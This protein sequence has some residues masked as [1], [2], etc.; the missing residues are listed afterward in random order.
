MRSS[1]KTTLCLFIIAGVIVR[2]EAVRQVSLNVG[3]N[4]ETS[5]FTASDNVEGCY[6][7]TP[8]GETIEFK[9]VDNSNDKYKLEEDT[10]FVKCKV[11]VKSINSNDAGIWTLRSAS[12]NGNNR[13][14]TYEVTVTTED[15]AETT[16]LPQ[17]TT[18]NTIETST[19]QI[20]EIINID[21]EHFVTKI[22][23]SHE[24]K[25]PEYDFLNSEK[26]YIV[27]PDGN[28]YDVEMTQINGI[29][30]IKDDNVACGVKVHIV[31]EQM[32]GDWMLIS[33]GTRYST[34]V[35]ERRLP[36][37]IILEEIVNALPSEITV[38]QG[39]DIYIRLEDSTPFYDTCK[40]IDP[41][42]TFRT[43]IEKDSRYVDT[44]GFIVKNASE[45]DSGFWQI[46]YGESTIY[47]AF[48]R[49]TVNGEAQT[50][51][52]SHYTWTLDR[53]VE[54]LMGPENTV[55]CR[56]VDPKQNTVFDGFGRCNV[57]LNRV[58]VEHT[59]RWRIFVGLEGR[60]LTDEHDFEV[61]V[62]E[63][64]PK[65]VVSTS[66]ATNKPLVT[67][68]CSVSSS[69]AVNSCK[70]RDPTGRILLANPGVG[71]D[72]YTFHGEGSSLQSGVYNHECGIQITN[73]EIRD[74]GLWSCAMATDAETYYGFL[75]VLCPWAM[76]DPEVAATVVSE[77]TLKA[78]N[79]MVNGL[80][81]E[82]VT[83]SCSVQSAIR[84]CYF[85]ARNGT[86][87]SVSPGESTGAIEYAGAGFDAGDCAIR[88]SSLSASD[89]GLWSCHVGL[90][91]ASETEHRDS[92]EVSIQDTLVAEQRVEH[93]ALIITGRV[94]D[95]R[96]VE[97]CRFVRIDGL[98]FTTEN[99]PEGYR[100]D[101]LL[102][103]GRCEIRIP[104][105][106]ILELHP[107]T[108]AVRIRGQ[109]VEL[110]R[111]TLHSLHE[112]LPED[113]NQIFVYH[114]PITWLMI[115]IIGMSLIMTGILV[116]PKKNRTWTYAKASSIRD[117]LR[118]SF[119]K[120]IVT[121]KIVPER[122]TPMSA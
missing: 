101:S 96:A 68:T 43:N 25:I 71:E 34:E 36:F 44:C 81:G 7:D 97:Y 21:P 92:F 29:E 83:M 10:E 111:E 75:S 26:C 64:D 62:R 38:N 95:D 2:S 5:I 14:E 42:D 114:F 13:N 102:S 45:N 93:N 73:P 113:E 30:V 100:S 48:V 106:S 16:W 79:Q 72:R 60:V 59:G 66:V 91:S 63:A 98:G 27:T 87:F 112:H 12:D 115:L 82:T 32:I 69:H 58:T 8:W 122:N 17:E 49:V 37:T 103:V 53:P 23:E 109:D 67:L 31:S 35:V 70:F 50:D 78:E 20:E 121:E 105:P 15:V 107:W 76:Q 90:V 24:L 41:L 120:K 18:E 52:Q 89:S 116:G 33:R 74:L 108:V 9:P 117:S 3:E 85:R 40:L 99:L 28:Q 61:T 94:H 86:T 57:T 55:Y 88:F 119:G 65:P 104:S 51:I 39:N 22:G 47:K 56:V 19:A 80:V 110:S 4:L 77:P 46:K 1:G 118:R 84:Y 54:Q 6:L 11:T